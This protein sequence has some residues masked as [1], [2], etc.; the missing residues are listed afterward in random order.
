MQLRPIFYK[1]GNRNKLKFL[2]FQSHRLSGFPAIKKTV[3]KVEREWG[4]FFLFIIII[5]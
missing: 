5:V 2:I 4:K 1:T 3:T